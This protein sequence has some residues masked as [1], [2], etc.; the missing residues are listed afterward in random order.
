MGAGIFGGEQVNQV[1]LGLRI[2]FPLIWL[3]FWPGSIW[4]ETIH[5]AV[6]ASFKKP[7]QHLAAQFTQQSGYEVL[8]SSGSTGKLYAQ[9]QNGAPYQLYLA[10]DERHP[11]QLVDAG[12]AVAGT[13]FVY[14]V[15]RLVLFALQADLLVTL[16][17]PEAFK[18]I[19]RLALANPATAPYGEAAKEVLTALGLWQTLQGRIAFGE[20]VGHALAFV[21]SGAAEAGFVA[22]SQLVDE[23]Q[24]RMAGAVWEPDA[25]LYTPLYH[26]GVVLQRGKGQAGVLE[27]V[28]F[29]QSASVRAWLLKSGF[30]VSP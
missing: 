18:P 19:K 4:G 28:E 20:N 3:M 30:G 10:A 6:T 7:L 16:P 8:I 21:Q 15:G 12:L 11:Q 24:Q 26:G 29:L 9:I 17:N 1:G 13:R 22:D 27:L 23:Q 25:S 2:F 14:A 5:V